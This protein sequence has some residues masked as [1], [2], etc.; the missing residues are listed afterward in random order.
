MVSLLLILHHITQMFA[1]LNNNDQNF[2]DFAN[3]HIFYDDEYD[4]YLP[5]MV[6][7]GIKPSM[8]K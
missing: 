2:L 4:E 6:Y 1:N 3:K 8:G 5:I 7:S